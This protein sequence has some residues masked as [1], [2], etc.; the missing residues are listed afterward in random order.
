[1]IDLKTKYLIYH[2]AKESDT[3]IAFLRLSEEVSIRVLSNQF[4][5]VS[6][7]NDT[8][9][10]R[11]IRELAVEELFLDFS[12]FKYPEEEY[13][14]QTILFDVLPLM[15]Y[16]VYD[17][18]DLIEYVCIHN[19]K[20]Y[21]LYFK[22]LFLSKYGRETIETILGFIKNDMNA[23]KASKALF[24][25]RNTINYRLDHFIASSDINIRTFEGAFA[26]YLLFK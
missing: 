21:S 18:L 11:F 19:I 12:A 5:E 8:V 17:S 10:F 26:F 15:P 23:S 24:M 25:H 16:N 20:D 3:F 9:D 1:M 7:E 13:Y 2:K 14:N 6:I 22:S 4:L